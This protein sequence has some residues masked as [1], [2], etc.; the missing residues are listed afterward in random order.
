MSWFWKKGG[1][2]LWT[3]NNQ[4]GCLAAKGMQ[5]RKE[6]TALNL[7]KAQTPDNRA[8]MSLETKEKAQGCCQWVVQVC[9][10][11][12][13]S[14]Q[15][16]T[17]MFKS[18]EATSIVGSWS[19][20]V[21]V[22]WETHCPQGQSTD[23]NPQY[24]DVGPP[25]VSPGSLA[26]HP[27]PGAVTLQAIRLLSLAL[28]YVSEIYFWENGLWVDKAWL[29]TDS[30]SIEGYVFPFQHQPEKATSTARS[31]H[32]GD[33]ACLGAAAPCLLLLVG[34]HLLLF[35]MFPHYSLFLGSLLSQMM[36]FV[37]LL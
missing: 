3:N 34:A 10:Y 19:V 36:I 22:R 32:T 25:G 13:V 11:I 4:L 1:R 28:I 24:L 14:S 23:H 31:R 16:G 29:I 26:F 8:F 33:S 12:L 5:R 17:E 21:I 6:G 20:S 2:F 37:F 7:E 27:S 15:V 18:K 30:F 9:E 35:V